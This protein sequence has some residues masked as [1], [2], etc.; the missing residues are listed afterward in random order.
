[1]GVGITL[2]LCLMGVM[3]AIG[4]VFFLVVCARVLK[5]KYECDYKIAALNLSHEE[6]MKEKEW[7]R[8]VKWENIIADKSEVRRMVKDREKKVDKLWDD[9]DKTTQLDLNRVAFVHL[10]LSGSKEAI[11]PE[12]L[13]KEV[14]KVKKSY[15]IIKDYV[16]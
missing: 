3:F 12:T 10:L 5:Y 15:E 14:E 2:L 4:L 1:M 13:E 6:K 11:T 9:R 16:K 8:K 7:E